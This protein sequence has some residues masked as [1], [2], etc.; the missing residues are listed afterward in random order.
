MYATPQDNERIGHLTQGLDRVGLTDAQ[1]CLVLPIDICD[2]IFEFAPKPTLLACS[3]VSWAW[4]EVARPHLFRTLKVRTLRYGPRSYDDF[5]QFL[6]ENADIAR[7]IRDLT[8]GYIEPLHPGPTLEEFVNNRPVVRP[9]LLVALAEKLPRLEEL[10]L[11]GGI[12]LDGPDPSDTLQLTTST[13]EG[14][15]STAPATADG[16]TG[17]GS[18]RLQCLSIVG[19]FSVQAAISLIGILSAVPADTVQMRHV[20]MMEPGLRHGHRIPS[21]LEC[22]LDVRTLLMDAEPFLAHRRNRY[23]YDALRRAF[24]P[25]CLR[26]LRLDYVD[27]ASNSGLRSL[28]EIIHRAGGDALRDLELP[29]V[30]NGPVGLS[31][32]TPGKQSGAFTESTSDAERLTDDLLSCS[33]ESVIVLALL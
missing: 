31:E 4:R 18:F 26:Q 20:S 2:T 21:T 12:Y 13:S 24:A 27:R 23:M 10:R 22:Q 19:C 16:S 9:W 8:L 33:H 29:F 6:D 3:R 14:T 25:Q 1:S 11:I 32:D 17:L 15:R 30:I 7:Y 5:L 28:G